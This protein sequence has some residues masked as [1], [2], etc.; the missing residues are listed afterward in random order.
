[1]PL[2][3]ADN[4][5]RIIP[6]DSEFLSRKM[7]ARGE[8]FYDQ[9]LNTLRLYD[10]Q[11]QG[12]HQLAKT[13]LSNI[14][15][16]TFLAKAEQ[17]GVGGVNN[18][19][20]HIV[21]V[22]GHTDVVAD[23]AG[24][25]LTLVAG[26]NVHIATT[27]E[28]DTVTISADSYTLP[29][30]SSTSLGGV[31]VDNSTITINNGVITANF[32]PVETFTFKVAA[33]DSTQKTILSGNTIKFTGSGSVTTG[34]DADGNVTIIGATASTTMATLTDSVTAALTIDMTYLPAITRLN[35]TRTG[36]TAFLFDQYSGNNPTLYAIAGTTIAFKLNVTGHPFLIQDGSGT[37]FSTGL[38]HVSTAGVVS[39]GSDALGKTTGTLY[40]KIPQGTS[41][42]Y[43]Y[44]CGI[45][46]AMVGAITIKDIS[47]L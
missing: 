31:I 6:R 44:Q 41:G 21:S 35:V 43:R 14:G 37:N 32:P 30:A 10:G 36:A 38:V 11:V 23:A 28:T 34:T 22:A 45:H 33:D 2:R 17:A 5:I 7:G 26:Q 42:G 18:Y 39:T 15:N 25:T 20:F 3:S 46:V 40:W 27:P 13:D 47:A 9:T 19:S 29:V 4:N 24:S 8:I 16:S 12:G 1:M